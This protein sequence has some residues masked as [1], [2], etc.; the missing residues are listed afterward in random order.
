VLVHQDGP[1]VGGE[2][3]EE[4]VGVGGAGGWADC[5]E[6]VDQIAQA[7]FFDCGVAI[8]LH[9]NLVDGGGIFA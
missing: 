4:T 9:D 3:A 1:L 6:A 2:G 5:G 7:S 8:I